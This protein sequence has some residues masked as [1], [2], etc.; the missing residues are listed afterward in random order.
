MSAARPSVIP[1]A[2]KDRDALYLA[3]MPFLINGGIFV[4]CERDC[5]L[6]DEVCLLLSLPDDP[7][8][9]PVA[10]KVAWITPPGST[11]VQ[12]IGVHFASDDSSYR[13]RR[14]I[15]DMLGTRLASDQPTY[16]L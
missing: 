12:G 5:E 3:Y 15:E 2:I 11:R 10:G 13:L 9:Y 6:G 14:R 16:T 7:Q 1:H 8:R 4:P